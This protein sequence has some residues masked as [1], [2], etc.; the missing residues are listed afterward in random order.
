M[1]GTVAYV[2]Q[3]PFIQNCTVRE[4]IVFGSPYKVDKYERAVKLCALDRDFEVLPAKDMTE[5]GERGINL[6]GGQKVR[7]LSILYT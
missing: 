5:I 2:G 3:Q 1:K 4:N 7:I 6:S